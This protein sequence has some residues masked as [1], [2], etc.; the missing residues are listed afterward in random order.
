MLLNVL[1]LTRLTI[2]SL[3]QKR[4][5]LIYSTKVMALLIYNVWEKNEYLLGYLNM[6]IFFFTLNHHVKVVLNQKLLKKIRAG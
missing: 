6:S 3:N 2:Q 1:K 5:K 4:H